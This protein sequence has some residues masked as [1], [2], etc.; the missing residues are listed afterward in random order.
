MHRQMASKSVGL[1][2]G[3]KLNE[4]FEG[5]KGIGFGLD[6]SSS[7]E[8]DQVKFDPVNDSN[9]DIKAQLDN[10]K[11]QNSTFNSSLKHPKTE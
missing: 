1:S 11:V 10:Y 3:L 2:K 9:L 5:W 7:E 4:K 6:S 8:E